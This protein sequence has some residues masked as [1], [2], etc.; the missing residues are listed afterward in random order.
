MAIAFGVFD[1]LDKKDAP[2][3]EIYEERLR[4]IEAYDRGGFYAYHLAEHHG[5][6]LGMAP[7]PGVFLASVAQRTTRLR[8]GPLVYTLPL[9]DPLRLINEI[10]MLD[11]LSGGRFELGVGRGISAFE[12]AFYGVSHLEAKRTYNEALEVILKGLT[13]SVLDHQGEYFR[14]FNVPLELSPLQ[15]PHP[16]LWYGI[17][18]PEG[19]DWCAR[20]RVNVCSNAPAAPA[21][22]MLERYTAKWDEAHGDPVAAKMGIARHIYVAETQADAERVAARAQQEWYRSFAKVWRDYGANPLRYPADFEG[23]RD[24]GLI[25]CGTP[26]QVRDGVAA[27]IA[28]SS[29]TYFVCRFAYGDLSYDEASRSLDLFVS[30]VM[31][32]FT[33]GTAAGRAAE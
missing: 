17:G 11:H 19:I 29:C 18:S 20:E 25:L 3:T 15:Q 5:S 27:Q 21:A 8:F 13:S 31:P 14:Y 6:P 12:I 28:E 23:F 32:H 16:P 4:L 7:S 2:L 26:D 33:G 1:H 9:Y 10:C 24:M 22:K 30:D